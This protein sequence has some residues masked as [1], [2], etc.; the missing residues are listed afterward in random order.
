MASFSKISKQRLAGAHPLLQKIMNEAINHYDFMVLDSQRD[1][2]AQERAFKQGNS[3]VHFGQS[4]HNW[5]PSIALDVA[6]FPIDWNDLGRFKVLQLEIILPIAQ[7]MQIPIRQGI[8]WNRDGNLSNDGWDDYPHVELH[9]WREWAK[10]S[11]LFG[12]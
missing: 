3:K 11:H 6:P 9:P 7:K 4:A 1:R 10:K 2:A 8:D 5:A 12:E